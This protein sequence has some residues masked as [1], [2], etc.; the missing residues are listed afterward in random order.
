MPR[1][2]SS[3][4]TGW[5]SARRRTWPSPAAGW[6]IAATAPV[7]GGGR[8]LRKPW[9]WWHD[10][11]ADAEPDPVDLADI[12]RCPHA[13]LPP[14]LFQAMTGA[15]NPHAYYLT[16]PQAANAVAVGLKSL[17]VT[18]PPSTC[19]HEPLAAYG[20][21]TPQARKEACPPEG[22]V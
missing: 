13:R 8:A 5:R 2:C 6:G 4:P 10:R 17:C 11:S 15:W 14:L 21:Y 1:R 20:S 3:S 16:W 18:S 9:A 7:S 12:V 22:I 19:L